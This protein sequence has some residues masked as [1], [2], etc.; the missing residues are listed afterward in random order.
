[1]VSYDPPSALARAAT[2]LH[3][4]FPLLSDEGSALIEHLGLLNRDIEAQ[5]AA[6]DVAHDPR[7]TGAAHPGLFV[8]DRDGFVVDRH[9]E[10][11]YRIRPS[12]EVTLR[13]LDAENHGTEGQVTITLTS[14]TST[15]VPGRVT[16]VRVDLDL[17]EGLHVYG[18][19]S[20][21]TYTSLSISV[22]SGPVSAHIGAVE[23][24]EAE[25]LPD[26]LSEQPLPAY[27]GSVHVTVPVSI[28]EPA[29]KVTL[30]VHVAYQA[31]TDRICYPPDH[32]M[33]T[34]TLLGPMA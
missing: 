15:Y 13:M 24:P 18:P 29:G 23:L 9:F 26:P 14:P 10:V 11:D 33:Q 25:R 12:G 28:L 27:T 34:L 4:T 16:P 31:C 17:P 30:E 6:D 8:L 1:V 7:Y 20:P 21:A 22:Q 19:G 5:H 3:L 32:L 2:E